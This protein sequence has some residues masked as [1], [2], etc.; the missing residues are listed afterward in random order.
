[1]RREK[2]TRLKRGS[3]NKWSNVASATFQQQHQQTQQL[4]KCYWLWLREWIRGCPGTQPFDVQRLPNT[5]RAAGPSR[6]WSKLFRRLPCCERIKLSIS[7]ERNHGQMSNGSTR[8]HVRI[9]ARAREAPQHDAQGLGA[10]EES[11]VAACRFSHI[12]RVPFRAWTLRDMTSDFFDQSAF[13]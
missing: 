9:W 12:L 3:P 4:Y 6:A 2:N 1:M 7:L 13:A 10:I 11:P 8:Y 5:C